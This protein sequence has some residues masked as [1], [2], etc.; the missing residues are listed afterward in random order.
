MPLPERI[1][2]FLANP[3]PLIGT[4]LAAAAPGAQLTCMRRRIEKL[5]QS[6]LRSV[7]VSAAPADERGSFLSPVTSVEPS[8]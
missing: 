3:P 6:V 1:S 2:S 5:V 4:V 8:R 7:G